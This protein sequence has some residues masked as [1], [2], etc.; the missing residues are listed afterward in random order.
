GTGFENRLARLLA[1]DMGIDLQYA[2][3][4]DRRGFVRKTMG[5]GVCDVVLGVPAGVARVQTTQ[6]YYRSSYVWVQRADRGEPPSGFDDPRLARMRIGV[7]LIGDDMA[8]SPPGFALAR[9]VPKAR[10][11][12]FPIPGET[13]A[14]QRIVE[15]LAAGELDGALV[16]GPQ[17]GFFA[18]RAGV[19]MRI[20]RLAA[21]ADLPRPQTFEFD[22]AVGVR[23]GDDVLRQRVQ[24]ALVRHRADIDELLAEYGVP[25][26][27]ARP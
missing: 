12:G 17:A 4:P 26:V 24:D 6:P 5:A 10:V 19:P 27:E 11:T 2:W 23:R 25:R 14:A 9:H 1:Q 3:L 21:P 22:I 15:A 7:Q 16:W 8:A 20:V 13:P 18:Q